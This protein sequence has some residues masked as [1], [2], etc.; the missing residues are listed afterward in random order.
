MSRST[1]LNQLKA[2]HLYEL[3]ENQYQRHKTSLK[4]RIMNEM[5]PRWRNDIF[6]DGIKNACVP[7]ERMKLKEGRLPRL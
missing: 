1:Y 7:S 3:N 5:F 6:L 4:K 2:K